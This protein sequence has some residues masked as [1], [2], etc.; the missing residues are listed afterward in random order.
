MS[1]FLISVCA[2]CTESE[3]G[4]NKRRAVV[5]I[6][7]AVKKAAE[8]SK[9]TLKQIEDRKAEVAREQAEVDRIMA[10]PD[11]VNGLAKRV[12]EA[13]FAGV[14]DIINALTI[15]A[16]RGQDVTP[17]IK[18]IRDAVARKRNNAGDRDSWLS[19]TDAKGLEDTLKSLAV[20]GFLKSTSEHERG[21][22]VWAESIQNWAHM[23]QSA[24]REGSRESHEVNGEWRKFIPEA[25]TWL[26]RTGAPIGVKSKYSGVKS[27]YKTPAPV[28]SDD[29]RAAKTPAPSKD[30][31]GDENPGR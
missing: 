13:S 29:T 9:A 25:R 4:T 5:N 7:D 28:T 14:R 18:T 6:N 31:L 19:V 20:I 1:L 21:L 8:D 17:A 22:H 24:Q 26:L 30:N 16:W 12:N 23:G 3:R 11:P 10:G 15:L 27:K 2:G